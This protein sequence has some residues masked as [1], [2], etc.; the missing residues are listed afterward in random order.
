MKKETYNRS[1]QLTIPEK[2]FANE[3]V[4]SLIEL[5]QIQIRKITD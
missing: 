1:L 3:I 4:L 2:W 5:I